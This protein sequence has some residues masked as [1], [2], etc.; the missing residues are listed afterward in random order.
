MNRHGFALLILGIVAIAAW[1]YHVNYQTKTVLNDVDSLRDRIAGEHERRQVLRVEWAYL[2][3]PDRLAR[4]V[5]EHHVRLGL[6]QIYSEHL[7]AAAAAPF[8]PQDNGPPQPLLASDGPP[9]PTPVMR[10]VMLAA[11]AHQ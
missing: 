8:P 3:A 6:T 10:P 1:A 4:L 7:R 11:G 2:N 5:G 9:V